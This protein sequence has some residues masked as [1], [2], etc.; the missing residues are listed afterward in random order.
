MYL[1]N[2][3]LISQLLYV[4]YLKVIENGLLQILNKTCLYKYF[5][6]QKI[7]DYR[8]F[9]R[10]FAGPIS[11]FSHFWNK[12]HSCSIWNRYIWKWSSKVASLSINTT[13]TPPPTLCCTVSRE[14]LVDNRFLD[15]DRRRF[16]IIKICITVRRHVCVIEWGHTKFLS[17]FLCRFLLPWFHFKFNFRQKVITNAFFAIETSISD[18]KFID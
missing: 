6:L 4:R 15:V 1:F 8:P 5:Y 2:W 11:T 17:E 14:I 13:F 3:I 12:G 16:K 10:G 7:F 18:K 9:D